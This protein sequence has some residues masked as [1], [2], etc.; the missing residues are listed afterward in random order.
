[1]FFNKEFLKNYF[2]KKLKRRYEFIESMEI[3][4]DANCLALIVPINR[5]ED[6]AANFASKEVVNLVKDIEK[7][8]AG[9]NLNLVF[10]LS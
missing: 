6:L 7:T 8:L 4:K 3:S 1:M 9:L 10:V 5:I 2:F